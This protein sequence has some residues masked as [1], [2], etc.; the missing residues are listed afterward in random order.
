[1]APVVRTGRPTGADSSATCGGHA[2]ATCTCEGA[3]VPGCRGDISTVPDHGRRWGTEDLV[4]ALGPVVI[5][6]GVTD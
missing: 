2:D 6:D 3:T 4:I 5:L 1:M